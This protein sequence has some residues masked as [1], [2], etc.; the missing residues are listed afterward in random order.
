MNANIIAIIFQEGG[1][2]LTEMLRTRRRKVRVEPPMVSIQEVTTEMP[3]SPRFLAESPPTKKA[4]EIA[5]GCVPCAIGH[6][7]TCSGLLAESLRFGKK[8]GIDSGEVIDRVNLC[9]DELNTMERVDLRPELIDGLP[10]WE[11]ELANKALNA[12]RDTRHGLEGLTSIDELEAV[13]AETQRTRG[14]IGRQWFQQKL[15]TMSPE[16]KA[17]VQQKMMAKLEKGE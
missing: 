6:F 13:A 4:S 11:K 10:K 17:E 5:T 2:F 7:G 3:A 14:E 12:S 16:Q 15:K 9:L 8:E 1:R